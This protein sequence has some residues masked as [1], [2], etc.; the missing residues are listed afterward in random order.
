MGYR[1]QEMVGKQPKGEGGCI[2]RAAADGGDTPDKGRKSHRRPGEKEIWDAVNEVG[3]EEK[4]RKET[5]V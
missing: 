4:S 3:R 2:T 1:G 5:S